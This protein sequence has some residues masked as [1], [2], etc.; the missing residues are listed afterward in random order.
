MKIILTRAHIR[1]D[2]YCGFCRTRRNKGAQMPA[3]RAEELPAQS[4]G[5]LGG[6]NGSGRRSGQLPGPQTHNDSAERE[7]KPAYVRGLC[8]LLLCRK[9]GLFAKMLVFTASTLLLTLLYKEVAPMEIKKHIAATLKREMEK[10]GLNFMEFS[11]ELGIPRTTLQGYLKGTSS[12]RADSLEELAGKLGISPAELVSGKESPGN[13][14]VSC[15]DPVLVELSALHPQALPV[16]QDAVSLLQYAFQLSE[17]L[18]APKETAAAE[19]PSGAAYRYFLHEL[20][21]PLHRSPAYGILVKEHVDEGW[22]T[23]A[24]VAP[25]SRDKDAVAQLAKRCTELQLSPEHLLDT[26][27]DFLTQYALTTVF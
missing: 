8:F 24:V 9:G 16:A 12:P 13:T 4:S 23:I 17:D 15:L 3:A 26:I 25:F 1:Q 5:E 19:G 21:A 27:Q 22:V 18:Y 6:A 7:H 11:T 2:G 20:K 10:R 14:G